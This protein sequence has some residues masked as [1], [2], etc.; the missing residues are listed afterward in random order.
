[1]HVAGVSVAY[2]DTAD[3]AAIVFT[4]DQGEV[5][6]LQSRVAKKAEHHNDPGHK[7]AEGHVPHS[8]RADNVE[9]GARLVMTPADPKD[10]EALRAHVREH[11]EHMQKGGCPHG[12][13]GH[14]EGHGGHDGHGGHHD[15][16][17]GPHDAS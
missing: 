6:E 4:T 9:R 16:H 2:E 7:R 11:V 10:L 8:A 12:H 17:G 3:G 15:G 5:A 13:D 14:H 1:M